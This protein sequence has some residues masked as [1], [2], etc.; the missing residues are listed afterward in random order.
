MSLSN[1]LNPQDEAITDDN[2]QDPLQQ[3]LERF[4]GVEDNNE[5]EQI[6]MEDVVPAPPS[7]RQALDAI[8]MV[9]EYEET[10]ADATITD[11]R[12]LV[13]LMRQFDV[14]YIQ[15]THQTTI[16]QWLI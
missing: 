9:I 13:N 15:N 12:F 7:I 4:V 2:E 6:E 8:K 1:F 14:K 5:D 10:Q 11:M 3:V 16:E